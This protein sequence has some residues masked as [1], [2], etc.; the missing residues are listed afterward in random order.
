MSLVGLI[1]MS[2]LPVHSWFSTYP[3]SVDN[4]GWHWARASR[5]EVER[6][7]AWYA[8][9]REVATV[10]ASGNAHLGAGM[11]AVYSPQQAWAGNLLLAARALCE[12]RGIGGPGSGVFASTAQRRAADRL[13]AGESYEDVLTGPKVRDFA[14]LIEHGGDRDPA[15]PRVVI[16]RH[17]LSVACGRPLTVAEYGAAPLKAYRRADG[18][19]RHRHYDRVVQ[20]YLQAARII[21]GREHRR[22]AAH[23]V[24]AVTWLVRQR[25]NQL[26]ERDRGPSVL[27]RGRGA[28]RA[29]A[30][31]RWHDVQIRQFPHLGRWP[32]T[33]YL[34][35]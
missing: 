21:A 2:P 17:A 20:L 15:T 32:T 22:V 24:Q 9:A 33:G 23:Q 28:A 12:G 3:I 19:I 31:Q 4:I 10:I 14:R 5:Q 16:D 26:T 1:S 30:E 34:A 11:L 7:M 18:S 6:G 25:L 35:A 13:L 27:D 8:D 29:R